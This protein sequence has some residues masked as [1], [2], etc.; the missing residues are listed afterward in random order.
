M[1]VMDSGIVLHLFKVKCV[2]ITKVPDHIEFCERY[3]TSK[4]VLEKVG[5]ELRAILSLN[6]LETIWKKHRRI[7]IYYLYRELGDSKWNID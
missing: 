1:H 7:I 2:A 3:A 6:I 5:E 4:K